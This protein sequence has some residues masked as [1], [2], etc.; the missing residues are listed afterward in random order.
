LIVA[1]TAATT[2]AASLAAAGEA[3]QFENS[4]GSG[5]FNRR[6]G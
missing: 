6:P 3:E 4:D 2:L 5:P 1:A